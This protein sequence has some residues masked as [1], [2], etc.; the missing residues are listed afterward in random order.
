MATERSPLTRSEDDR[1]ALIAWT[2]ACAEQ[3]LPVFAAAAPDDPR[4]REALT[5]GLAFAR[6]ELRVGA[7]RQLAAAGH[8]A[9]RGR[10]RAFDA[11]LPGSDRRVVL[12][13][14]SEATGPA[15]FDE[16]LAVA[17]G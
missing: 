1:R 14:N 16:L 9:T 8:A 7:A 5:G 17:L 2:V 15:E 6:G 10:F 11:C 3:V 12:F 13:S 4:P